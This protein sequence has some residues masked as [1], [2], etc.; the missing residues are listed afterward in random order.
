MTVITISREFGSGGD[1]LAEKVAH[2]LGYLH[3]AHLAHVQ[4]GAQEFNRFALL[5]VFGLSFA[6]FL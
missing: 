1:L 2:A 5:Q 3:L 6:L 4:G